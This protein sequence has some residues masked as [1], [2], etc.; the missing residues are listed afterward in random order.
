M[1]KYLIANHSQAPQGFYEAP[2][3][4]TIEFGTAPAKY[5]PPGGRDIINLDAAG[6]KNAKALGTLITMVE[7]VEDDG[8]PTEADIEKDRFDD[9]SDDDLRAYLTENAQKFHPATGRA[10]LLTA[11]REFEAANKAPAPVDETV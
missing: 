7:H 1:T 10:K 3:E 6:V 8:E 11:A 2:D 9:M 4:D 5:I